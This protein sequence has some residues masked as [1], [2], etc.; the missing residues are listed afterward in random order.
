MSNLNIKILTQWTLLL[1]VLIRIVVLKGVFIL[2]NQNLTRI[3]GRLNLSF[4]LLF[5]STL[6]VGFSTLSQANGVDASN[7]YYNWWKPANFSESEWKVVSTLSPVLPP[8][9]SPTNKYADDPEAAKLGQMFFFD[10]NADGPILVDIPQIGWGRKGEIPEMGCVGCHDPSESFVDRRLGLDW[11]VSLGADFTPRRTQPLFNMAHHAPIGYDSDAHRDTLWHQAVKAYEFSKQQNGSRLRL[12]HVISDLYKEEYETVFGP[13]PFGL[14]SGYFPSQGKPGDPEWDPLTPE[15]QDSITEVMVNY[16]KA[17]AA[18]ERK[19]NT[20]TTAFDSFVAGNR[21]AISPQAKK[22][23]KLFVGKAGC[24]ACHSGP[25]FTDNKLHVTGVPQKGIHVPKVDLGV[26]QGIPSQL[27]SDFLGNSKWSDNPR[28]GQQLVNFWKNLEGDR[29]TIGQYRT[30]QLRNVALTGPYF[31]SGYSATLFEAIQIYNHPA[32]NPNYSG[33]LSPLMK[34]LKLKRKEIK[35]LVVFLKTLN[36][37]VPAE[38]L[39]D[40]SKRYFY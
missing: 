8:P 35:Q 11:P 37:S 10:V 31:H 36:G 32:A 4:F 16:G 40:T 28:Y 24:V 15:E 17:I 23:L 39:K 13:L 34:P 1:I 33:K 12:A 27:G 38:L 6:S 21:Q 29:K 14:D 25:M 26:F 2:K 3:S 30:P 9:P 7:H 22:G 20:G 19:L 5:A 18:Y